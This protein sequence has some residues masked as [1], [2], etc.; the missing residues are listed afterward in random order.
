MSD[1]YHPPQWKEIVNYQA[2]SGQTEPPKQ[3]VCQHIFRHQ[4]EDI[5]LNIW[6][7]ISLS[8]LICKRVAVVRR[9]CIEDRGQTSHLH[10]YSSAVKQER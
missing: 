2:S 4:E 8:C 5:Y 6:I 9:C 7:F 3:S 10:E 1:G